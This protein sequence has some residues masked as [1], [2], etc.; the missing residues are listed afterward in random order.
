[1]KVDVGEVITTA[2]QITW[3]NKSL[4]WF[5]VF[6]SL[7]GFA[8]FLV[9]MFL[10]FIPILTERAST[11]FSLLALVGAMLLFFLLFVAIYLVGTLFQTAV[12][13]GVWR[14]I[15]EK[16]PMPLIELVRNSLPFWGRVLGINLLY[17]VGMMLVYF[18]I[19]A[20]ILL[21]T[22]ITFGLALFCFMP[23]SFLLYPLLFMAIVWMEQ[24]I[25]GV[26]VD[27]LKVMEAL[28]GAWKMI[29]NNLLVIALIVVIV[30]FGVSIV[31]ML[32][33]M[34]IFASLFMLPLAFVNNE[35]NWLFLSISVLI[36]LVTLPIFA[37][38][39]G[40]YTVFAKTAWVLT[41]LHLT[42]PTETQPMLTTM[43]V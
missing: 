2:W 25:N 13:M 34:P 19:D 10:I 23:V 28:T 43:T 20:V 42:R 26:V 38:F 31:S 32:F 9:M 3:K 15:Q 18:L 14:G 16:E 41:Y 29:R 17:A 4:W 27:E 40:W 37:I 7:L 22:L 1:M 30:Y 21:L 33:S 6:S 36:G 24:G 12:T 35:P 8:I 39:S 5:G 11:N